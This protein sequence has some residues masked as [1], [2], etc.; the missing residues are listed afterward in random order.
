MTF[1]THGFHFL[2][3]VEEVD[4]RNEYVLKNAGT[5]IKSYY[6]WNEGSLSQL[7]PEKRIEWWTSLDEYHEK[8]D[9]LY[10]W[11]E[12]II[13]RLQMSVP[14]TEYCSKRQPYTMGCDI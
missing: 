14:E 8:K 7:S 12:H 13:M 11:I 4:L 5:R 2:T 9:P 1:N 10:K 6:L 3:I